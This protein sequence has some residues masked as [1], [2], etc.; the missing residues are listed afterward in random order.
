MA[1]G[2]PAMLALLALVPTAVAAWWWLW[3]TRRLHRTAVGSA[4]E[5]H[6]R[7]VEVSRLLLLLALA[8][9]SVAAA[10]PMWSPGAQTL[11]R[12]DFALVVALD[13]SLSM[14]AEDVGEELGQPVSRF[15]A[16]LAEIHRLIDSRRGD[17]IGL[18]V[19]S[20][21]AFLRFPL[22]RD[23]EAA[24]EVLAALQPG[25]ALVRPGSDIGSAI[26]LA[27][28][29]IV[30]AAGADSEE[31]V[32]GAIAVVSDGEELL[33][34][35]VGLDAIAAAQAA[36]DLGI[37]VFTVGVGS[38][39]GANIPLRRSTTL[40]IDPRS[41]S[42]VVTRLNDKR[43]REVAEAGGG[44]F[45]ELDSPGAIS[46]MNSDLAA[47]D[48]V[49]EVIVVESSLADQ[50]QWFAGAAVLAL[51][52]AAGARVFGWTLGR[53]RVL[54]S[55]GALI[56]LV[57]FAGACSGTS[58][59]Q[60]NREGVDRYESGDYR[61]ALEQWREAQRLARRTEAGVHPRLHLNAGRA[62][63]RLGEFES[64]ET[65]TLSALRADEAD[66][67]A[68]AWF[69]VG[70]HRWA[71]NDLLGARAAFIEALREAP[72]MLDA[73]INLELVTGILQSL[74]QDSDSDS[75]DQSGSEEQAGEPVSSDSGQQA[76]AEPAAS[77]EQSP[78]PG[79]GSSGEA[80]EAPLPGQ[81][82]GVRPTTPSFSEEGTLLERREQAL[83][84]LDTA[85]DE[86]PLENA[87]LDQA[88][89]VLDAMRAVPGEPLA[90][91]RLDLGEES[92]DW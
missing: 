65:E 52:L 80:S 60:T 92:L 19:F 88:L 7:G 70:N 68:I 74:E 29:T 77:A 20:G 15:T 6:R 78:D 12:P 66:L 54:I 10:R 51:L 75:S 87:S 9:I 8:L 83:Q 32:S 56:G 82:G 46:S 28:E 14:A 33:N 71:S 24:L 34:Q 18:V 42:P 44:R 36:R 40:K 41:G 38:R 26:A 39:Q 3:R 48:Q 5:G 84:A 69:H 37:Q 30:R 31:P 62:L 35:P 1:L 25:E 4:I 53:G 73:K 59:E 90:A 23:H 11:E 61:G 47:I 72:T 64:A 86:L 13:V 67:R 22:T 45:V 2:A 91:G 49:R 55:L 27:T 76:Q 89:A 50:F 58:V 16:A 79:T 81:G 57:M 21:D 63:H 17:R 85:L 43:L